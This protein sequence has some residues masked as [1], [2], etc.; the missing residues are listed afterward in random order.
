MIALFVVSG[1]I[2]VELVALL[3]LYT[4][5]SRYQHFWSEKAQQPGEITYLALR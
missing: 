3:W 5:V 4:S 1:L 2:L